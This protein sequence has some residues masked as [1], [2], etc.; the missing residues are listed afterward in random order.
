MKICF[1]IELKLK[2]NNE[3]VQREVKVT[4]MANIFEFL[5]LFQLYSSLHDSVVIFS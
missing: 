5:T 2:Q 3:K 4:Q 1:T